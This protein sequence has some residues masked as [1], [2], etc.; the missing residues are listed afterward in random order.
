MSLS[1]QAIDALPPELQDE[2]RTV[3]I[4]PFPN[5]RRITTWTPP[6]PG[7]DAAKHVI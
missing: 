6:V 1:R 7:F 5:T 2:A 4:T 3:D